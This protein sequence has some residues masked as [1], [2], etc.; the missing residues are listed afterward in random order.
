MARG[1]RADSKEVG[2]EIGLIL[3][4]FFLKTDYLHY[5]LFTPDIEVDITNLH[6]AQERYVD[7]LLSYIPAEVR[8]ILDVGGGSGRI[9]ERLLDSGYEVVMVSPSKML[10][11]HATQ[12]LGDRAVVHTSR[13][14]ELALDSG[15][16]LVLFSE[17]F[18]Y[19]PIEKAI[20]QAKRHLNP[21]GHI[22]ICDFFRTDAEGKSLLG[23]GHELA[24]W[25]AFLEGG[26]GLELIANQDIT[27]ET[28]PT[29]DLA[30]DLTTRVIQP[31]WELL[32]RLGDDR[33]STVM[34]FLRWKFKKKLAKIE[35]KHLTGQRTGA[36]FLRYKKYIICLLQEQLSNGVSV[37]N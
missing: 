1:A 34:R 4:E 24:D 15:F 29:M 8:S 12:L 30:Q 9:A 31:I 7:L 16:D 2:L 11:Q 5:G 36:N 17:S 37:T 35:N 20:S 33:H 27:A 14:E 18:Q 19:I 26:H 23:G 3:L 28:A 25:E 21:Q 10:N 32:F 22:L 6:E 13:F